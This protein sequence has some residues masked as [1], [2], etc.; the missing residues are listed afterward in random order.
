MS[1]DEVLEKMK[2]VGITLSRPSLSR[3][4]ANKLIPQAIRGGGGRGIGLTSSY[5]ADT[6]IEAIAA[7]RLLNGDWGDQDIK[8]IFGDKPPRIPF[9]A[10]KV[11]R[12]LAQAREADEKFSGSAVWGNGDEFE[13]LLRAEKELRNLKLNSMTSK[14]LI[15]VLA[16][17][18]Q[19]EFD[20]AKETVK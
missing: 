4:E 8:K 2:E 20:R 10:V 15:A 12:A 7:W 5:P 11:A 6:V 17:A 1:P 3:Y 18:W 16:S 13:P 19:D 14:K 9:E